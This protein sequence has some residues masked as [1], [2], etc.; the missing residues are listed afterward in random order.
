[1][2]QCKLLGRKLLKILRKEI[3]EIIINE[4]CKAVEPHR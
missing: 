4:K 2:N 1:M 3:D